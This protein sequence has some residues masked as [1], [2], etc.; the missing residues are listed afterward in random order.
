[1][2]KKLETIIGE[3]ILTSV[4]QINEEFNQTTYEVNL[5]VIGFHHQN[6]QR[7]RVFQDE[8][9]YDIFS[10][11]KQELVDIEIMTGDDM[12]MTISSSMHQ[13]LINGFNE[14]RLTIF[15]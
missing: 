1:M 11:S 4:F 14:G 12:L 8:P 7:V 15:P 5:K 3:D 10:Q 2:N 13:R 9:P 6:G